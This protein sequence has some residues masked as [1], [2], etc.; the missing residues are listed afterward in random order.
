MYYVQILRILYA[1]VKIDLNNG[2]NVS[3]PLHQDVK[4]SNYATGASQLQ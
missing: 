4:E 3:L 2:I 1:L